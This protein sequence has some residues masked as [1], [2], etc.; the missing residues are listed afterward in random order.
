[1]GSTPDRLSTQHTAPGPL[2]ILLISR[3]P[4]YPLHLG[5]RL[6]VWHLARELAQRGHMLDLLAYT[7]LPTD[8]DQI[9][10][11][12][13]FFRQVKLFPEPR[14]TMLEYARRLILPGAR[15]PRRAEQSWSPELWRT[16]E[17][18]LHT[19]RYDIVHVFGGVQV[20]EFVYALRGLPALITPYESYS[21]YLKRQ[22]EQQGGLV[23]W[24]NHWLARAFERWMFAPYA[25]TVVV[26]QPDKDELLATNPRLR[27]E[28]I[29]NGIDATYFSANRTHFEPATLLFVGNYAYPPNVD[30]A[31]LLAAVILPEVRRR[32]PEAKLLLVG[33]AP[34]PEIQALQ[35][36]S[37]TVTGHVPDI[38]VYHEQAAVF[39]CP[40]RTGAGIKNKVLEALAMGVPVVAT[41][42]SV[43]G[44]AV[45]PNHSALLTDDK[46]I[47]SEVVRLLQDPALQRRLS[48]NGRTLVESRYSWSG[49]AEQYI[50]L[51]AD[52]RAGKN[53]L[54]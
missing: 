34:P 41:P 53:R 24:V 39:V 48:T 2:K 16:I 26:A 8:T 42:L 29:S 51:Y 15:F 1:M 11:Y 36:A 27:V 35:S 37:V 3:C 4:P 12:Q 10:H 31:K 22:V 30:A 17:M 52:I 23:N 38:R 20:Y 18:H 50:Q 28:V 5:D 47:A 6:I 33:N 49:V 7:Q 13:P 45:E 25:C 32:L 14:R 40:L 21:L 54:D 43:D 19:H 44:I 9:Q 46:H